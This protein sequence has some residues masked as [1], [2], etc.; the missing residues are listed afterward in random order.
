MIKA[1]IILIST[2]HP[3]YGKMAY[4]LL[5][6]LKAADPSTAVALIHDNKAI[7]HLPETERR[8]FDV[9]IELPS[10][11]GTGFSA[12]LHLDQ[13]TPFEKTL[14][15]DVDMLW[16]S[17][18]KPSELLAELN[19]VQFT[20]ITEGDSDKPNLKYYF[21]ADE[22]EILQNYKI[23][24][25]PQT[26]SEVMYFEKGTKV[27]EKA[28]QLNPER[29]L[30]TIRKFGTLIPDELYF[31]IAMGILNIKPHVMN[32]QPAYWARLNGDRLPEVKDLRNGFYLLSFGS[33]FVSSTLQKVYDNF[34]IATSHNL[35]TRW[36]KIQSKKMWA[37]GRLKM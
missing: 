8:A 17:K 23:E 7:A 1:G 29:K 15:L 18:R 19:G 9:L 27:F 11:Y 25:V 14:Y 36:Y 24:W 33:N 12:K 2:G 20:I 34:M 26:R 28:R 6:T 16:I 37:P 21:W 35:R 22:K 13:L 4:N 5:N 3:N 32:W 30:L 31:N 10:V